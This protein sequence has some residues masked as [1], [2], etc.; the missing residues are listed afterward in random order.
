MSGFSSLAV[1]FLPNAAFTQA[2]RGQWGNQTIYDLKQGLEHCFA[3][4]AS[5]LNKEQMFAI[6]L[7]AYGGFAIHWIQVRLAATSLSPPHLGVE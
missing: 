1:D 7:G 5:V 2:R 4:Y 6:G 3:E